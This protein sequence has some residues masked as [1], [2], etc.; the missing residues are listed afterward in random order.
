MACTQI[1]IETF[2]IL[3]FCRQ[4]RTHEVKPDPEYTKKLLDAFEA[5]PEPTTDIRELQSLGLDYEKPEFYFHLRLLN[6]SGFV[7]RD[8]EE[9]GLGVERSADG[10]LYWSVIPLR[11]TAEGHT[12]AEALRSH[13]GFQAVK[14]SLVKSS[15]SI[16]RDIAVAAFKT[17][18]SKHGIP[19]GM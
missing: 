6:D 2:S 9:P 14:N 7:E 5:S 12:F 16:M 19:L 17:E 11:L 10:G 1:E 8:D 3:K 13:S 15:L 18:I 4:A